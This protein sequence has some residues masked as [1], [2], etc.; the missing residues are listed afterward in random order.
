MLRNGKRGPDPVKVRYM[1]DQAVIAL[2][3]Q[4]IWHRRG[5]TAPD[6]RTPLRLLK[7]DTAEV[8]APAP[9]APVTNRDKVAGAVADGACTVAAVAA[10]TGLNKGTVSQKLGELVEQGAVRRAA[11]GSLSVVEVSA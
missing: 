1:D 10:A 2:P 9:A 11:D 6:E 5:P 4:P 8:P 7:D 3:N